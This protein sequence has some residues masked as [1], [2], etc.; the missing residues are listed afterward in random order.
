VTAAA[1]PLPLSSPLSPAH[2]T[3][4]TTA[5]TN[6]KKIRRAIAVAAFD[7]YTIATFAGLTLLTGLTDPPSILLGLAMSAIAI[8]ELRAGK[9]LRRLNPQAAR[10]LGFNQLAFAAVLILY[11]VTR[12][13]AAFHAPSPYQAYKSA[14]PAMATMLNPIEDLSRLV[15]VGIY[16]AMIGIACFAQGGLALY[17]FTRA[18]HL[19]RYLAATPA[20]ILTMQRAG[21]SL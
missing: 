14:D 6:C 11:A 3:Q 1:P 4:L 16:I 13:I 2:L 15:T 17:Y 19:H 21:V 9:N 20:W 5:R 12:L 7:G 18:K 10:T 8:I